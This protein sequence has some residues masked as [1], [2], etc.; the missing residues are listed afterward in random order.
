MM[1]VAVIPMA[2]YATQGEDVLEESEELSS[3][4]FIYLLRD[5]HQVFK[6]SV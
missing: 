3:Q 4:V 2:Q 6:S 5:S 1:T